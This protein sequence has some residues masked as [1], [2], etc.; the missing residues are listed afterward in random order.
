MPVKTMDQLV[1]RTAALKKKLAEKGG[2][3]EA[4][5]VRGLKK[6]IRRSQRRRRK[7]A[8]TVARRAEAG[9]KKGEQ[10]QS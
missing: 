4:K 9:K 7:M 5:A 3:M 1:K 8:A 10:P 2:S 6:R